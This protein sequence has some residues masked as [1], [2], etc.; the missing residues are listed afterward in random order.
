MKKTSSLILITII[1]VILF[2]GTIPAAAEDTQEVPFIPV[3]QPE[4]ELPTEVPTEM[5]TVLPPTMEP[6]EL[7]RCP[8]LHLL[9]QRNQP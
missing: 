9:L 4:T 1:L 7:P 8:R 6:T 3:T 2:W 5:P